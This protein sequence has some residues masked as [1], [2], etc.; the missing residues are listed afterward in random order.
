MKYP[1]LFLNGHL[2]LQLDHGLWLLDT[3][4]PG[5]FGNAPLITL[6]GRQFALESEYLGLTPAS[7]SGLL[8]MDCCGL[9]GMDVLSKFDLV[10]DVPNGQITISTGELAFEGSRV[11]LEDFLGIP[12]VRVHV[13]GWERRVFL[14]TGAQISY[15]SAEVLEGF[16]AAGRAKDFYPGLGEFETETHL[17]AVELGGERYSLRSGELPLLLGLTLQLADSEGIVGN[18]VFRERAAAY[19]PRRRQ[20]VLETRPIAAP[21]PHTTAGA[22]AQPRQHDGRG[23]RTRSC[24]CP[25]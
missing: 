10:L 25:P 14:D 7:L 12:I 2:F 1:L 9:L 8:G 13:G 24:F 11:D 18:E 22:A 17:V 15:F 4:A 6:A 3:G 23:W 21:L 16:P 20:L 19:F 5:S